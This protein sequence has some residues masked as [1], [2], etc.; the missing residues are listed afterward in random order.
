MKMFQLHKCYV[1]QITAPIILIDTPPG[2]QCDEVKSQRQ[3]STALEIEERFNH[4]GPNDYSHRHLSIC[5]R[6]SWSPLQVTQGLLELFV[7]KHN[8][9]GSFWDLPSCFYR[10][11]EDVEINFCLPVTV[12]RTSSS[13]E[14]LY[15]IRYPELK[16]SD[17][18]WAIRQ[19]GLYYRFDGSTGQTVSVLFSPTPNSV[20][21]Q[22]VKNFL[23]GIDCNSKD[24]LAS[25]YIHECLFTAYIPNWRQYIAY[26]ECKLL[27]ETSTTFTTFI[28]EPLRVG[29]DNLSSLA[30]LD[31]QFLQASTLLSHGEDVLRELCS[32]LIEEGLKSKAP[33]ILDTLDNYRRQ[34][35]VCCRTAA[36]LQRRAQTTAQ[37]LADTLSFRDQILAKQQ[38]SSMLQLNKSAVFLTTLTLLYLPASFVAV[39]IFRYELL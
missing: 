18:K 3:L 27:P 12:N 8:I 24:L 23:L 37:L 25:W 30:S 32:I 14:V 13:I 21:H 29:Y 34:S 1:D 15:T 28:E 4:T 16:A 17:G 22:K 6:T 38:N 5:Q 2:N 39:N 7:S 10:R 35:V 20:A 19:S 9:D 36:F 11:N 26:L 33:G 31:S